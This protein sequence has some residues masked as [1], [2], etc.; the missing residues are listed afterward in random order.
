MYILALAVPLRPCVLEVGRGDQH[1]FVF[2]NLFYRVAHYA[3][4]AGTVLHKVQFAE[5]MPMQR[6]VAT[7]LMPV[8]YVH[9]IVLTQRGY[10][11][12]YS[13]SFHSCK[14]VL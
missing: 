9:Q 1:E 11:L 7:R 2:A 10:F 12:Q 13:S 8:G 5:R 3:L 6:K 4:A 14:K